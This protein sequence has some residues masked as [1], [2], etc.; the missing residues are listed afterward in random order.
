MLYVVQAAWLL[1][2]SPALVADDV[3]LTL[4]SDL[5]RSGAELTLLPP[6][7]Q[8]VCSVVLPSHPDAM[9]GDDDASTAHRGRAAVLAVL[10]S[11][12]AGDAPLAYTVAALRSAPLVDCLPKSVTKALKRLQHR[13]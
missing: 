4:L 8:R 9:D 11:A 3:V 10:R 5:A 12:V 2:I 13:L 6:L 1:T 7:L